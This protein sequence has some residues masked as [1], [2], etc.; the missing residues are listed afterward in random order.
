M[1]TRVC[2]GE[3]VAVASKRAVQQRRLGS[4]VS[5][6]PTSC[7][8]RR[9]VVAGGERSTGERVRERKRGERRQRETPQFMSSMCGCS[10]A[11]DRNRA[12]TA[13]ARSPKCL[14][15]AYKP[16]CLAPSVLPLASL[17]RPLRCSAWMSR[18]RV[19]CGRCSNSSNAWGPAHRGSMGAYSGPSLSLK[20]PSATSYPTWSRLPPEAEAVS[21]RRPNN[22]GTTQHSCDGSCD[23]DSCATNEV[24]WSPDSSLRSGWF[25][26]ASPIQTSLS[27]VLRSTVLNSPATSQ[28]SHTP[29]SATYGM[30][31]A[32]GSWTSTD[33]S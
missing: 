26:P 23:S 12:G 21:S 31:S 24:P 17:P 14:L 9:L 4:D 29:P 22:G 7:P 19:A 5:A 11:D 13:P 25:R 28:P 6:A 2:G 30:L 3:G 32:S 20:P 33:K 1:M 16:S 18:R 27:G 8:Q 15:G 10:V